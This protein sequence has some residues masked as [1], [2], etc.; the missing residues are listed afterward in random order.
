MT[1]A[2]NGLRK[3][4][5]NFASSSESLLSAGLSADNPPFSEEERQMIAYYVAE[6]AKLIGPAKSLP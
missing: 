1:G 5:R 3:Q 2:V 4:V 6:L